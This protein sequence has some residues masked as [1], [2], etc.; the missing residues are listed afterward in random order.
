MAPAGELEGR[1]I[2]AH[3]EGIPDKA[4]NRMASPK[5]WTFDY[6]KSRFT[7]SEL[8]LADDVAYRNPSV[9][10]AELVNGTEKAVDFTITDWPAW[11]TSATPSTGSILPSGKQM[12][13]FVVQSDL[14]MDDYDGE[15]TATA[16]D[17]SQGV[18]VFD[19]HV[20]V[21]CHEPAWA[22]DPSDF[23]HSMT[24]VAKVN[25]GGAPSADPNDKLA[26]FVGNQLRGVAS[27][28]PMP[29]GPNP[30]LAFLTIYGNRATGE[31][32][33]FQVWDASD[34]K[35]YNATEE[36]HPFVANSS[37]GS[38]SAPVT[39][40]AIEIVGGGALTIAVNSGWTW[41]STN[42]TSPDM[43]VNAVLSDL[44][45]GEGDLIKSQTAFSQFADSMWA[46]SL[47]DLANISSY[48]I[49]LSGPGAI[50]HTGS[51]VPIGTPVPVRHG[52][53]W[54]GYL[55]Q[56]PEDVTDA[57]SDLHDRDL[58]ATGDVVKGQN[59]FA[60][61]VGGV[62]Y[63]SLDSLR[64]GHGYK[65][66]LSS[67]VDSSFVYPPYVPSQPAVLARGDAS[68]VRAP[69]K[70]AAQ[71]IEGAPAWFIDPHAYQNNMTVTAVLRIDGKE[72]I[73]ENDIVG[74]FVGDEC[75][76]VARPIYVEGIRRYEAFLMVHSNAV[77]GEKVNL[78][79]FDADGG[80]IYDV[81][82][83]LTFEADKVQGT[84]GAPLV[85]TAQDIHDEGGQDLP[86]AF[87]L[88]QNYPNP[89]NPT[90]V[91]DYDVPA[92]GGKVT[93]RIYDACGRLVRTLRDDVEKPGR[94]SVTW[95][96]RNNNGQRASTGV[97]FYRMTAPGFERTLKMVIMR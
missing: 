80:V 30:Y 57:L 12:V 43:S 51:P 15:V 37:I 4:G 39:L 68:E 8:Y 17:T 11:I 41:I 90:T 9:I 38:T 45:P 7:W 49:R 83:T 36:S 91:I 74:A 85:L 31:T 88:G 84:V 59:G 22:I 21:A 67:A 50:V 96:G 94:K 72:S 16:A 40:T 35:L 46:G 54:I 42:V 44:T 33:R 66:Y 23:E 10:T 93:L 69:E 92:G 5:E 52:W 34:C 60:E 78:R 61:Y 26:A 89:F 28:Q 2:V 48:M 71:S 58:V 14:A 47:I 75:R 63:G 79:A 53:N 82:E 56:G 64:T 18:A 32:V 3:V 25:I 76:G 65:L 77:G 1:R 55:P 95:D 62:W 6:R 27:L 70:P 29:V 73:D 86:K 24:M 13:S 81:T 20:T 87:A 97:Y 19:L